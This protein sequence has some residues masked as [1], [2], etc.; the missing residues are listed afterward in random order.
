MTE[1][2]SFDS[3]GAFL[4]PMAL[5]LVI[6]IFL[7]KSLIVVPQGEMYLVERLGKPFKGLMAGFHFLLPLL[8]RVAYKIPTNEFVLTLEN[9][10]LP[11]SKFGNTQEKVKIKLILKI[12]EPF[13]AAYGVSDYSSAVKE[14]TQTAFQTI[15]L[16]QSLQVN[17]LT[18]QIPIV[19]EKMKDSVQ[20]SFKQWGLELVDIQ[21]GPS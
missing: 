16:E 1:T 19:R 6:L 7:M 3:L 8:D 4:F 9:I 15:A 2:G 10:S 13:Q 12:F 20:E 18:S 14:L 11:E 21:L 5:V 17:T